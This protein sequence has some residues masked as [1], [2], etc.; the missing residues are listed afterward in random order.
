MEPAS[1]MSFPSFHRRAW[2]SDRTT[3]DVFG[4]MW[5]AVD[6]SNLLLYTSHASILATLADS[7]MGLSV[8]SSGICS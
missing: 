5:K 6:A 2:I 8:F 7:M 4:I 1:G 3:R